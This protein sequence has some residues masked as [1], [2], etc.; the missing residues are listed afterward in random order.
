MN[1]D[2]STSRNLDWKDVEPI[3]N[4][5]YDAY[6]D[7]ECTTWPSSVWPLLTEDGLTSAATARDRLDTTVR[8]ITLSHFHIMFTHELSLRRFDPTYRA[9]LGSLLSAKRVGKLAVTQY[10]GSMSDFARLSHC[11]GCALQWII[12][13]QLT[14]ILMTLR[15]HQGSSLDIFENLMAKSAF[16]S[17]NNKEIADGGTQS[18]FNFVLKCERELLPSGWQM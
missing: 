1:K 8:A 12:P 4:R 6:L 10:G 15:K 11:I 14:Q 3:V 16:D 13:D 2:S 7:V 9:I 18:A 17:S 5:I